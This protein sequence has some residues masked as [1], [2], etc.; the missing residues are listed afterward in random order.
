MME[1]KVIIFGK[2]NIFKNIRVGILFFVL[3]GSNLNATTAEDIELFTA[4]LRIPTAIGVNTFGKQHGVAP[5]V[6]LVASDFIRLSNE[7]LSIVNKRGKN[8]LHHYDYFWGAYDVA[9]LGLH[10]NNLLNN[11]D[12]KIDYLKIIKLQG[13]LQTLHETIL[14]L[15]EGATAC[16]AATSNGTLAS[17]EK[18]RLRCKSI[19]SLVRMLDNLIISKPKSYE[20][21][22]FASLLVVNIV[23]AL[24]DCFGVAWFKSKWVRIRDEIN[25][26][27]RLTKECILCG[28]DFKV[29]DGVLRFACGHASFHSGDCLH[30]GEASREK[31]KDKCPICRQAM[32][33]SKEKEIILTQSDLNGVQ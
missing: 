22:A 26:P 15:L 10:L 7:I 33:V 12:E 27:F 9:S 24:Y 4:F 20:Q 8:D 11:K 28:E 16:L 5:K 1:C 32:N 31:M 13:M 30:L 3:F 6:I 29:G 17:D 25:V 23:L 2:K 14:P 18:F 19:N 21:Y